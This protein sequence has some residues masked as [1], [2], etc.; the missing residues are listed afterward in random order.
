[1]TQKKVNKLLSKKEIC[2][3]MDE[4]I[5]KLVA[6]DKTLESLE[7]SADGF[8]E[9]ISSTEKNIRH[10]D[11]FDIHRFKLKQLLTERERGLKEVE[12]DI[13]KFSDEAEAWKLE[14]CELD[15]L[16]DDFK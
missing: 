11:I 9:L 1:M 6:R 8:R 7:K 3:Q 13:K 15:T 16:L 2:A 10:P 12:S 4:L 5:G 14:W